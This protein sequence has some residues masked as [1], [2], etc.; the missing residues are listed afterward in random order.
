M[1]LPPP[2]KLALLPWAPFFHFSRSSSSSPWGYLF[3]ISFFTL[4]SRLLLH[5]PMGVACMDTLWHQVG[6]AFLL[7]FSMGGAVWTRAPGHDPGR[8]PDMPT[9]GA[10]SRDTSWPPAARSK[11]RGK[12]KDPKASQAAKQR[13]SAKTRAPGHARDMPRTCPGHD[14]GH[15]PD[16]LCFPLLYQL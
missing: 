3:P 10:T 14:P 6:P 5:F 11:T 4:G 12:Q 7:R 1:A 8:T 13:S 16:M 9:S 2:P 15:A